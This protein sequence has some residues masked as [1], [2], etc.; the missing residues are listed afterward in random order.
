MLNPNVGRMLIGFERSHG[1]GMP[2]RNNSANVTVSGLLLKDRSRRGGR[3]RGLPRLVVP[4]SPGTLSR[5]EQ[6]GRR[7]GAVPGGVGPG[8]I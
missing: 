7:P 6:A 1:L 5:P 4:E 3:Q 2:L 8:G